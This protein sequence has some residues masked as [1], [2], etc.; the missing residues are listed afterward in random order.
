MPPDEMEEKKKTVIELCT[1][2]R[3]P[4]YVE[5]DE[6]GGFCFPTIGKSGCIE[7]EKG[8]ICPGCP[9]TEKIGLKNNFYCTRGSENEQLGQSEKPAE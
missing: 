2:P 1:C 9:V 8:C 4:S 6:K 3:C 5:C 7:S